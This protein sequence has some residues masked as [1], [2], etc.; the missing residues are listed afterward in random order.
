ME[1]RNVLEGF[2][3]WRD[4][5]WGMSVLDVDSAGWTVMCRRWRLVQAEAR[6][7]VTLGLWNEGGCRGGCRGG[8]GEVV[9]PAND[10][11]EAMIVLSWQSD[12][13]TACPESSKEG[14]G[15]SEC[16]GVG[17]CGEVAGCQG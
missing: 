1:K 4:G 5:C 11:A 9:M 17:G 8:C 15:R 10:G 2:D 6:V 14:D 12:V 3:T 13:G 16:W 7:S